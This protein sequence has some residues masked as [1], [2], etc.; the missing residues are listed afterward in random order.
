MLLSIGK[1]LDCKD[2]HDRTKI[3]RFCFDRARSSL[4]FWFQTKALALAKIRSLV[5]ATVFNMQT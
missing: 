5:G 2:L 4:I 1:W 3:K